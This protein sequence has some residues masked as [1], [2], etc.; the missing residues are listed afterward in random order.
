M[1]KILILLVSFL[2]ITGCGKKEESKTVDEPEIPE[3]EVKLED[4]EVEVNTEL[5]NTSGIINTLNCEVLTK[6]ENVDT[7]VLGETLVTIKVKDLNNEEKEYTYK[8]NV[9]DTTAPVITYKEKVTI[10]EGNKVDLLKNVSVKDN[11]GEKIKATVEGKY[12]TNKAGTYKLQYVA[13]DSSGNETKKDFSLVVKEKPVVVEKKVENNT[14]NNNN[15]NNTNNN[16]TSNTGNTA[17]AGKGTDPSLNG[18]KT[19]KG[20]TITVKNGITYIDG[21]MIANKTYALP[22]SYVPSGTHSKLSG[23][24]K[25]ISKTGISSNA[26]SAYT[27]MQAAAKS[28]GYSISIASGYRSYGYQE[29]LYNGYVKKNGKADADLGSARPGHSEHQTGLAFDLNTISNSSD[30]TNTTK[31]VLSNCYKYGFI[32]RYPK[33]K[34]SS[35]G[36]K[37]EWWHLRYVGEDLATKLYNNGNWITLEEYFGITSKYDY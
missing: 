17:K 13:K 22:S 33:G 6:E 29:G 32:L 34:T 15:N 14:Q 30:N 1:K 2:L 11:S 18:T 19:S 28:A 16:S 12:D 3:A 23:A 20:Y 24:Y 21:V 4:K 27:K 31:W 10:T 8:V 5:L 7:S 25:E 36:Y 35:T 9:I 26:Y 37:Y